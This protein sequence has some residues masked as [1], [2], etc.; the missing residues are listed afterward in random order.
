MTM[1]TAMVSPRARASA[2]NTEP[3]MPLR[4][5]DT[6]TCQADS[7][8]KNGRAD[9]QRHG[10]QQGHRGG[11]QGAINKGERPK[12]IKDRVP[13]GGAEKTETK[14]MTRQSGPLPQ[15]I[16]QQDG[17]QHHG[18]CKQKSAEPRDFITIAQ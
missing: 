6:T 13:Y 2:R 7:Q 15:L 3:K 16:N 14:L 8:Q 1:V 9:T 18:S 5:K 4:A 12:L 10:D 17:D 11:D